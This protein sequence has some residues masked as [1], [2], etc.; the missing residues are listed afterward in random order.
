[1]EIV[2]PVVDIDDDDDYL[3]GDDK[4]AEG[5]NDNNDDFVSVVA[6]DVN[7]Y[8]GIDVVSVY[9]DGADYDNNNA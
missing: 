5:N 4:C 7:E 9:D 6:K 2:F 3:G 8:D 1:M